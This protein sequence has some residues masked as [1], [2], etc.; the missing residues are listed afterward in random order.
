MAPRRWWLR[1]A[2][3]ALPAVLAGCFD[4][5]P[6]PASGVPVFGDAFTL[7]FTPNAFSGSLLTSLT[8]DGSR[9][10]SGSASIKL[11]VPA[12]A[13][14]FSGGAVL[15]E[16]P[17]DLSETNALVFWAVA[18]RAATFDKLG[19]GLNFDPYPSTWQVTLFDLPLTAEWTRHL[20]PIPDP[21]RLTAERGMLWYADADPTAYTAWLDDVRFDHVDPAV[22]QLEPAISAA[23]ATIGVGGTTQ[24]DGLALRYAD[25]DGTRRSVDS[26]TAGS[27]PAPGYWSFRSSNPAVARVDD[28]GLITGVAFGQATVTARL[29][30]L[31]AAGSVAVTVGN[32]APTAPI[33]APP[34]PTLPA[35]RVIALLSKPYANVPVDTWGADWSNASAGP[36]L[37]EVTIGGDPMKKYTAL[38]FVGI[39]FIGSPA[40]AHELDATAMTHL[41][42]DVWTPDAT[43]L[44]V[45]LVDFGAGK[46][47]GGGDDTEFE[48]TFGAGTTPALVTGQWVA[49]DLPLAS[50]TGLASRAHLAQLVLS[51]SSATVFVDN[52]YFHD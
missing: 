4:E 3:T 41:H 45:K 1:V 39:E 21:S 22:M 30:A 31:D 49:F 13:S 5:P 46:T 10:Q 35:A 8:V 28:A 40:G 26:T 6:V 14:G 29:G 27:G 15:A 2:L 16:S 7:G 51:S 12:A 24:V 25:F 34:A 47:F 32:V 36:R 20:V 50:F 9:V 23:S 38:Q 48:L 44:K 11:E 37:T 43:S 33:A 18:S 52:V 42:L 19:F 17:Q